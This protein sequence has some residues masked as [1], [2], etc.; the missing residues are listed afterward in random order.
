MGANSFDVRQFFEKC[1]DSVSQRLKVTGV[2][3]SLTLTSA[4]DAVSI[5]AEGT[6]NSISETS[7]AF[8]AV[9]AGY[10]DVVDLGATVHN[11]VVVDNTLDN[12]ITLRFGEGA[13]YTVVLA[14][15]E[16]ITLQWF[17]HSGKIEIKH[18]GVAPTAGAIKVR[19]Y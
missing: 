3:E 4:D 17:T 8:G 13:T 2:I 19:S 1:Y 6:T 14:A 5:R 12:P 7:V 11:H 18:N 16:D 10:G 9:G 15:N